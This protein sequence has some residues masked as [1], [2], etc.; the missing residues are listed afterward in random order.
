MVVK[1]DEQLIEE[2]LRGKTE[3]FDE[4]IQ[5]YS[6]GILALTTRMVQNRTEGED[7]AQESFFKAYKY[8]RSY[9]NNYKFSTWLYRI[10][11]NTCLDYQKK[12]KPVLFDQEVDELQLARA[13]GPEGEVENKELRNI[14]QREIG[15]LP[16]EIKAVIVLSHIHGHSYQEIAEIL[17]INISKVKNRLFKGRQ[18]LKEKLSPYKGGAVYEV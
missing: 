12:K 18:I 10:A 11:T 6:R 5:R 2:T 13:P 7:L 17:N 4:L 8:L 16:E 1:S 9:N 3:S 15:N 14:L